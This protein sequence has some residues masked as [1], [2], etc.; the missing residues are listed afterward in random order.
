[1][2]Q[3]YSDD[4]TLNYWASRASCAV[5]ERVRSCTTLSDVVRAE[6]TQRT[7]SSGFV[8][9]VT[10]EFMTGLSVPSATRPGN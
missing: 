4:Y 5:K 2:I 10:R 6:G 8:C 1:M 7:T 3:L 9:G